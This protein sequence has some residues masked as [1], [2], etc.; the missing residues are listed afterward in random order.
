MRATAGRGTRDRRAAV[1]TGTAGGLLAV[2]AGGLLAVGAGLLPAVGAPPGVAGAAA[3]PAAAAAVNFGNPVWTVGP[4]NDARAPIALSSPNEAT[5]PG[6]PAVV[7]GNESGNVFAY[8]LATGAAVWTYHT[9][10]PVNSSPSVA[11][12]TAGSSLDTV[13]VGTG[14]AGSPTSGG[15]Q[16]VS[17]G[18]GDQWFTQETNP[19]T[20]GTPHNGVQ[21][22]M[23]VGNLQGGLG[24]VAGSLGENEYAMTAG[25]GAVLPGFPWYQGD[26]NFSTPAL[27]DLYGN[28]QTD[29][30]QGGDST[31]GNSYTTPYGNGGHIRVLAPTGNAGQ[32]KP[33]GGLICQYTTDETVQS[34]PAVGEFLGG[35]QVG[36]VVGTGTTFKQSNTD[37]LLA[38]NANCQLQWAATLNGNTK[39]SPALADVLGN[40]Q[41]QVVEGTDNGTTGSVYALNGN[42][43]STIWA[44]QVGRV[45]GSVVTANLGGGYQDVL[46]PTVNGVAVLDG[47]TGA[48]VTT[49][50]VNTG[51]QNAPLVTKDPNGTIGIT[52]AGY[53]GSGSFLYH[54]EIAGSDGSVVNEQ[55]AWPQ[56]HHDAQLTGDAGTPP[57]VVNVPCTPPAGQPNGY[58]L[59]ASDG[60]I[61]A[62]GNLPFCG[63]TGNLTLNK[64]VVG[65][66]VM[67]DGGGYWE[68]A[69][70]GGLFA[71]GDAH[72]YGSMGGR[73][74]NQPV[75]GMAANPNGAG[76][77]EVA[78]DGGIFAFGTAPFYGSM[79][80][81]PLN[82]PIVGMAATGT[83]RG[84]RFVAA[85]GG[86]FD[87]GDAP[88]YGSM[89]GKPLNK[90]IVGMAGF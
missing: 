80:G 67:P 9:G 6:G 14:D 81:K 54:Y 83:G 76:Y 31:A 1:P 55:G 27:A 84:Y 69:S 71:F 7:V 62:Y 72:F 19:P 38:V 22:S 35:A 29:I 51:F 21:A 36:I 8:G 30:V 16:A 28:G 73:P 48:V 47:K 18:G 68:V 5:L 46:A 4:L 56:F 88:F 10:A 86:I 15:Y 53:Q 89:G 42:N 90:P 37:Q 58:Y 79:G 63:S 44:T 20:D 41:L 66:T 25:S 13:F 50:Q 34:S 82:Q 33:N 59:S 85:D 11:P 26:S 64:P 61:F 2:A 39:S 74:L 75:V 77:W 12:T 32:P 23:A 49:L 40:G 87:F 52:L 3:S 24:V 17:P 43:G 65:M 45:I 70:D 78:S 60:G 57:P